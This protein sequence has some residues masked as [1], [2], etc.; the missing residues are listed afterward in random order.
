MVQPVGLMQ[1]AWFLVLA[2]EARARPQDF[3]LLGLRALR[4]RSE[5]GWLL[6]LGVRHEAGRIRKVQ[7]EGENLCLEIFH[8]GS[9]Q[10]TAHESC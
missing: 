5:V 10:V 4:V 1:G 8:G 2:E 3:S 9:A 6:A 7:N